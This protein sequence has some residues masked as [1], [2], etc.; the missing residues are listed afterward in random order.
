MI[1]N[2]VSLFS[3]WL[4]NAIFSGS[5]LLQEETASDVG[6]AVTTAAQEAVETAG[7]DL[8]GKLQDHAHEISDT[9]NESPMV[10]EVSA[11]ILEPIYNAAE[12]MDFDSFYW[13]A[14]ALM[15]AGVVSFAAQLVLSKFFLLFKL[16]INLK[17]ILGDALGLVISVVGLVLT[18][19][20]AT[21]NSSFPESAIAVVSATAVGALA[22]IIFYWW[23]QQQEF[24]AAR[25][26]PKQ[27]PAAQA[28]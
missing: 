27:Q 1:V 12:Y 9:L 14:F 3:T 17:E 5:E 20:A 13:I 4:S 2:F 10:Q 18:T 21:Q 8:P 6:E 26:I 15:V 23:G 16:S 22:G 7:E 11:G 19:Q 24:K 25:R 28:R